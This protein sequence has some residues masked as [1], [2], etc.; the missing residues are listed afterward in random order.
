V[1]I[2][3]NTATR[4]RNPD[5]F[6]HRGSDNTLHWVLGGTAPPDLAAAREEEN[7]SE[8]RQRERLWYV[9]C[10][11]ARDLLIVPCLPSADSRS[12]YRIVNLGH[13]H[14]PELDLSQL[15]HASPDPGA[16]VTNEQ[17]SECFA[18][19]SKAVA[20]ASPPLAWRRPSDHDLDRAPIAEGAVDPANETAEVV[21]APGAGRLRG[22]VLHKL[23]EEFLTGELGED[24]KAVTVRADDL[25]QQ[26]LADEPDARDLPEPAEMART[27]HRTLHLP[28]IAPLRS[29]LVP[30][31]SVWS[32]TKGELIA[33]RADATAYEAGT[34]TVV[35]DWKSDVAPTSEDRA[36]Y[37]GQLQEYMTA[38]GASRGAVVY[39]SLGEIA[40]V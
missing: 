22:I 37:R 19:E 39:M 16:P 17:T 4:F 40:W 24:E 31:L 2:P 33:G 11:R 38:I 23:M 13:Q 21:V 18:A 14:L 34:P 10:T 5:E 25:L 3:I 30:E 9:A 26:L 7:R 32:A 35:L 29:M 15:P 28:E 1:V 6:V 27:A 8:T 12:W 36:Q 20:A